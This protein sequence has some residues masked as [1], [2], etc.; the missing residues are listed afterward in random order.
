[1][2][3]SEAE[4]ASTMV[5][6]NGVFE[7]RQNSVA[8]ASYEVNEPKSMTSQFETPRRPPRLVQISIRNLRK[9]LIKLD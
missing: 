9:L 2:A 4:V 8:G 5:V 7:E 3:G 6:S 1:M